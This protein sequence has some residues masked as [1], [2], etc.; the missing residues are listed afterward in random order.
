MVGVRSSCP[1][2]GIGRRKC[3]LG[4]VVLEHLWVQYRN[5]LRRD[6]FWRRLL[7]LSLNIRML[8]V[9]SCR[10]LCFNCLV[11]L[12]QVRLVVRLLHCRAFLVLHF[13]LVR[14]RLPN[15]LAV[16]SSILQRGSVLRRRR[17]VRLGQVL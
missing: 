3:H 5:S 8:L 12:T 15:L 16:P 10:Y 14:V 1:S 7:L 6:P 4:S 2:L 13:W 9:F 17:R 11:V